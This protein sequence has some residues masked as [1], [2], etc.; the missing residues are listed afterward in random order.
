MSE[1]MW[2]SELSQNWAEMLEIR[3]ITLTEL[4]SLYLDILSAGQSVPPLDECQKIYFSIKFQ[5]CS[6]Y[7]LINAYSSALL[8]MQSACFPLNDISF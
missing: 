1:W 3:I 4:F 5:T 7:L 8:E 6:L 2:N